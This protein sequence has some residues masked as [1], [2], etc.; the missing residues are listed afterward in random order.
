MGRYWS[1]L[2]GVGLATFFLMPT[3]HPPLFR[4]QKSGCLVVNE[5][6]REQVQ[7]LLR[8]V[9]PDRWL[10]RRHRRHHHHKRLLGYDGNHD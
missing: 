6:F 3:R 4:P 5:G 2:V 9:I 7:Q 8:P 1:A 10:P